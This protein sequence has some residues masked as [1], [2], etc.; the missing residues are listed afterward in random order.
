MGV[1]I[2]FIENF[3]IVWCVGWCIGEISVIGQ[4][5][6]G[7]GCV[8]QNCVMSDQFVYCVYVVVYCVVVVYEVDVLVQVFVCVMYG[9]VGVVVVYFGQCGGQCFY[10]F[11][12]LCV[13][14]VVF[15]WCISDFGGQYVLVVVGGQV[16]GGVEY[17]LMVVQCLCGGVEFQCQYVVE[18]CVYV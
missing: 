8:V 15:V 4:L 11:D 3:V 17:F 7:L 16:V 18:V 10:F 9:G 5:G 13:M 12:E 6:V 2:R 1:W 14:W